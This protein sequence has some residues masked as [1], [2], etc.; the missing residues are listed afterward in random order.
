MK[1]QKKQSNSEIN[2]S[3]D[4]ELSL[5]LQALN[6]FIKNIE[7]KCE[8]DLVTIFDLLQKI[9]EGDEF[10]IPVKI[11][12]NRNL[13]PLEAIC[14]FLKDT[15]RMSYRDIGKMLKRNERTIW[16]AYHQGKKKGGMNH[17]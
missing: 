16:T 14:I 9:R 7:T 6:T 8:V 4:R 15:L 13:G 1:R 12:E 11:F 17:G 5:Q 3:G 10:F 2:E